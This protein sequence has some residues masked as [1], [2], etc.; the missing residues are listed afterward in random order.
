M[1]GTCKKSQMLAL[2]IYLIVPAKLPE[3]ISKGQTA[4]RGVLMF[5]LQFF[6]FSWNKTFCSD[7]FS[8]DRKCFYRIKS[9][10]RE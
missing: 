8:R 10:N 4:V 3:H 2:N 5:F 9:P 6:P 1:G 7:F